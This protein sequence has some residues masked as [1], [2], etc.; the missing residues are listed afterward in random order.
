MR[1]FW[2]LFGSAM[3]QQGLIL[4]LFVQSPFLFAKLEQTTGTKTD[5]S[6]FG[7]MSDAEV[8]ELARQIQSEYTSAILKNIKKFDEGDKSSKFDST[9]G[10]GGRYSGYGE[11]HITK[12]DGMISHENGVNALE[13]AVEQGAL[14][15]TGLAGDAR[16]KKEQEI[17]EQRTEKLQ[18]PVIVNGK[19]YG[20]RNKLTGQMQTKSYEISAAMYDAGPAHGDA[21]DPHRIY[22]IKKEV[23]TESEQNGSQYASKTIQDAT[24]A[25]GKQPN[26][27]LLHKAYSKMEQDKYIMMATDAFAFRSARLDGT[28]TTDPKT[29]NTIAEYKQLAIDA[30][31]KFPGDIKAAEKDIQEQL[32]KR[33]AEKKVIN[34]KKL[35][36]DGSVGKCPQKPN[37]AQAANA[38]EISIDDAAKQILTKLGASTDGSNVQAIKYQLEGSFVSD[39]KGGFEKKKVSIEDLMENVTIRGLSGVLN[40]EQLE[41]KYAQAKQALDP[42]EQAKIGQYEQRIK[43]NECVSFNGFCYVDKFAPQDANKQQQGQA[44]AGATGIDKDDPKEFQRLS[45]D[46]GAHFRDT[47]EFIYSK[48]AYAYTRPL[49]EWKG[50]IGTISADFS[51][52]T[53]KNGVTFYKE[54]SDMHAKA[55]AAAKNTQQNTDQRLIDRLRSAGATPEQIARIKPNYSANFDPNKLTF[56]ELFGQNVKRDA[57]MMDWR[58]GTTQK[59]YNPSY[60][61]TPTGGPPASA[62]SGNSPTRAPTTARP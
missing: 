15:T 4:I 9:T 27:D 40:S 23:R 16:V 29:K 33:V 39:G 48:F 30:Y 58:K 28:D 24:L 41:Q 34:D 2:R 55:M 31:A 18:Q 3:I 8:E 21:D 54:F 19:V 57:V 14:G 50:I 43:A 35:C 59:F 52:A 5:A 47:R 37:N 38:P 51:E 36:W 12:G 26:L 45:G 10:G 44:A 20:F 6:K 32:A 60:R 61:Q 46:P 25:A 13:R 49:G 7:G 1:G 22:G 56:M 11:A 53:D 17:M 42:K 62:F